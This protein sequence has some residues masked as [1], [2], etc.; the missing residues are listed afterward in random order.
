MVILPCQWS[1]NHTDLHWLL[2]MPL[3]LCTSSW[4]ICTLRHLLII[5]AIIFVYFIMTHLHITASTEEG[6]MD[7]LW[8]WTCGYS[9]SCGELACILTSQLTSSLLCWF[10]DDFSEITKSSDN[11]NS[12]RLGKASVYEDGY[13]SEL[14]FKLPLSHYAAQQNNHDQSGARSR[15]LGN[16]EPMKGAI[17]VVYKLLLFKLIRDWD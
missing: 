12:H 7:G 9:L 6:W 1:Y 10:I 11:L 5:Y 3:Y 14:S 8:Q 2:I 16:S 17:C 15:M 4:P 13:I